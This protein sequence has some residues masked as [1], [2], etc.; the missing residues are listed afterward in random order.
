[1]PKEIKT[2][3]T[4]KDIIIC[5]I[6]LLVGSIFGIFF[7]GEDSGNGYT[8]PMAIQ[9]INQEYTDRIKEITRS[10]YAFTLHCIVFLFPATE[11]V[12]SPCVY[13]LS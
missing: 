6:G 12:K 11:N 1:M 13:Y 2:R 3:N 8:M 10:D 5:M 4:V 7:S 9:E